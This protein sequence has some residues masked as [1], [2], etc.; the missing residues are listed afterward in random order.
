MYNSNYQNTQPSIPDRQTQKHNEKVAAVAAAAL[1]RPQLRAAPQPQW[2]AELVCFGWGALEKC[3]CV[4]ACLFVCV[5]LFVC[6]VPI[7]WFVLV[8]EE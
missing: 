8:C 6:V 4:C 5:Y 1:L 2:E 3:V 7:V